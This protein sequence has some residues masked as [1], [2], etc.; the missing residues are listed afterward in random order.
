M[1]CQSHATHKTLSLFQSNEKKGQ[2]PKLYHMPLLP[3]LNFAFFRKIDNTL[4][5]FLCFPFFITFSSFEDLPGNALDGADGVE[6]G[7]AVEIAAES[8]WFNMGCP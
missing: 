6:V 1:S 2:T 8:D 5:T 7:L 4:T 3:L